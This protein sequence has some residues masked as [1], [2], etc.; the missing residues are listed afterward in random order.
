MID[1]TIIDDLKN[2]F[3]DKILINLTLNGIPL[4]L[5]KIIPK[6][7]FFILIIVSFKENN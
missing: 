4:S 3:N 7:F 2:N 1:E 5:E 6:I